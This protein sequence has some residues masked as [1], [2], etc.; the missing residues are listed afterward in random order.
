MT[1]FLD[2]Q[3]AFA[4][5]LADEARGMYAPYLRDA[6]NAASSPARPDLPHTDIK[7][8]SSLVTAL[9]RAIE[10]HL[11]LRIEDAYPQHGIYGEEGGTVR[12]DAEHVWVLDPID[13]TAPFIA[14]VP[15]FGTLIALLH[16]GMPVLGVMD[17]PATGDRWI[18]AT[19]RPTLHQGKACRTRACGLLS[20]AMLSTSNPDF[21]A[22]DELPAFQALRERTRWRI[23][24]GCCLAY[25]LLA[26]GRTDIAID[27]RLALYD[28][29]PFIPV[30][31]GA[32]GVITDWNGR[33]L[34]LDNPA[35]RILAAGDPDRHREALT[36]VR[37]AM[38]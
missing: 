24:G 29:A 5:Q 31:Q 28:Y 1:P 8:D 26:A 35:S 30:I 10:A 9:D 13:G 17:F 12:L 38:A 6:S 18:G 15:V 4:Q 16:R 33:A 37:H 2:A 32:G 27:A 7:P 20:D 3:L 14:G 11:R 25:G 23:Y 22:S 21:Y 34:G 19:G 36:L